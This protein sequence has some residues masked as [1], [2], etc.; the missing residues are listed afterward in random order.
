[1]INRV[2][3]VSAHVFRGREVLFLDAN[4]WLYLFGPQ[5]A[6]GSSVEVK[7]Y[8]AAF[9][10]ILTAGCT[11]FIDALVLSEFVNSSARY[12]YNVLPRS[13]RP[14]T[15]KTYRGGQVFLM[16]AKQI[17]IACSSI[18]RHC[19]RIDSGFGNLDV[20]ELLVRYQAG[21]LDFNDSVIL[22]LCMKKN[23]TLVTHDADFKNQAVTVLTANP[24]LL[25]QVK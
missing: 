14:R 13:G 23:L 19:R 15:F 24:K 9:K 8:S 6:K 5:Y 7:S 25:S 2:L 18:L 16:Q 12:Y 3:S 11:I 21:K 1:M 17:A 20:N 22:Q 10:N 4:V